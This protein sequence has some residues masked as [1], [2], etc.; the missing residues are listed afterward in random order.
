MAEP[1]EIAKRETV[2]WVTDDSQQFQ[3][4]LEAHEHR[5]RVYLKAVLADAGFDIP[6][7]T[8]IINALFTD[9]GDVGRVLT[10]YGELSGR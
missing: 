4:E 8:N 7:S 1:L 3:T 10:A 9:A 5:A 2:V 6:T